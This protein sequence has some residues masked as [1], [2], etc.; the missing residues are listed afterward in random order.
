MTKQRSNWQVYAQ[1][2]NVLGESP[3]WS[4]REQ[5]LYWLDIARRTLFCKALG[6]RQS[7]SWSLPD[8]AGCL[9][10]L[11][12]GS[13]ALAMGEGVHRFALESQEFKLLYPA[14][15]GRPGTR[16]ND[17]RVD[18]QGR[19]W[20]GTMQN[21][22]GP[23]G[24]S[25][26]LERM[27]G[28]LYRFDPEGR[29]HTIEE[30]VGVANTLAWSPDLKTFYFADS[31]QGQIYRYDFDADSGAVSNKQLFFESA[32]LGI[33]DGSAM[34]VEGCLWNARWGGGAV[35]RLTPQGKIDRV[36]EL[37]VPQP[38][39]CMFGGPKLDTLFVTSATLGLSAAQLAQF[40]LSGSVFA[41]Q[42]VGQGMS[43]PPLALTVEKT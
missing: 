5:T 24:E 27:D 41:I 21:N 10:E 7:R 16:F 42:G 30:N 25:V 29:V 11:A 38:T 40:P 2:A 18:P 23:Q 32:D 8:Y 19:F 15:A 26:P 6:E 31:M 22:F 35:L 3:L 14:P 1:E 20:A 36:I 33:P 34:D 43:V 37:P 13:I 9:A 39:S 28:A 12:P 17:G 4:S